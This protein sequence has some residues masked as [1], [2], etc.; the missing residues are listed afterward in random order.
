[1]LRSTDLADA[2]KCDGTSVERLDGLRVAYRDTN[3]VGLLVK[4]F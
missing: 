4:A 1:M 2:R 3:L